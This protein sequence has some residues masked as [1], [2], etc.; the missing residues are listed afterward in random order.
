VLNGGHTWPGA[1]PAGYNAGK[2]SQDFN[3]GVEILNFFKDYQLTRPSCDFNGDVICTIEDVILLILMAHQDPTNP[4]VDW[5]GDGKY[6]INDAIALLRDIL[7]GG[8]FNASALLSG[9]S[10]MIERENLS[11]DEIEYIEKALAL[12]NL[13]PEEEALFRLA[14]YGDSGPARLPKVFSLAQNAPNP[15]NPATTISYGVSEGNSVHVTLKVYNIR[16]TLVRTLVDE[17]REPGT[18]SVFWDGKDEKGRQV[19][20]GVFF[21]RMQAGDFVQT[22]KMVLLK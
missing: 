4:I 22:R 9:A 7:G 17:V 20:S 18:Y 11:R 2:T 8:S 5:D 14:L 13:T 19:A 21:Y 15:F 10:G 6:E 1:G 3:A 16:G 12:M